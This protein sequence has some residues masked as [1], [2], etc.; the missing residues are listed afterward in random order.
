M[1]KTITVIIPALNEASKISKCLDAT[2][3]QTF[4][5][6][7]IIVADGGSIDGTQNI[8]KRYTV[9]LID[10]PY[11]IRAGACQ[12]GVEHA[13]GNYVAF[14]DADCVPEKDWL[15]NLINNFDGSVIGLAGNTKYEKGIE[16]WEKS[17]NLS[18]NTLIG[19]GD[20]IQ[21]RSYSTK[22]RVKS[23]SGCNSMY[24]K[25]DIINAG[26]FNVKLSGGEDED[27]NRRLQGDIYYIPNAIVW[28]NHKMKGLKQYAN[29]MY[30]YGKWKVENHT[31]FL[32]MPPPSLIAPFF[33]LSLIWTPWVVVACA[34]I[35]FTIVM[36]YSSIIADKENNLV[37]LLTLP[38]VYFVGHVSY[39]WGFWRE[40]FRVKRNVRT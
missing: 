38:V 14:T 37:Y 24:R 30:K 21:Y 26:G 29:R 6:L 17:I 7:E 1:D 28:H 18:L 27:L 13:H 16:I 22:R 31:V 36:A 8:V 33:M 34:L 25:Q 9:E 20:S 12:L 35:Y 10:N 5:P 11:V 32:R 39:T 3:A 19:S 23:T 4:K 40:I 15:K 2:L